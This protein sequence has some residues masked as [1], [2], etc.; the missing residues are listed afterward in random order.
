MHERGDP[1]RGA[2]LERVRER[3]ERIGGTDRAACP[4]RPR[5]VDGQP[6]AVDPAHLARADTRRRAPS[7][8]STMAFERTCR[9]TRQARSRSGHLGVGRRPGAGA[10]PGR[11]QVDGDV[12]I[13][14]Q[15]RTPGAPQLHAGRRHAHDAG[16][17]QQPQVGLAGQDRAGVGVEARRRRRPPGTCEASRSASARSTTPLTATTPP[18]ALTGSPARAPSQAVARSAA[19]AAP[20][21]LP[22]LTMTMAAPRRS[23]ASPAA[24]AAS[25]RLL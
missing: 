17:L 15:D 18:K 4:V 24:A 7:L 12:G 14:G 19:S 5:L 3:E 22:C 9:Q 20:Q 8:T 13:G 1:G 11:R 2:H 10:R 25:S 21:G 16:V 23:R 6:G